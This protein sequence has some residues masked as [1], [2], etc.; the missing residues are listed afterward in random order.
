MFLKSQK[1]HCQ[2]GVGLKSLSFNLTLFWVFINEKI[3]VL[4]IFGKK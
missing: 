1:V 3:A 4:T 2:P